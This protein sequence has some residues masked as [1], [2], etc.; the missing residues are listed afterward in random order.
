MLSLIGYLSWKSSENLASLGVI[1]AILI[2]INMF[3][4]NWKPDAAQSSNYYFLKN[5]LGFYPLTFQ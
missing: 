1:I 2:G 3:I 4:N 5:N